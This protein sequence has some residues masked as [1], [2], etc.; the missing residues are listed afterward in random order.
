MYGGARGQIC[1]DGGE[2]EEMANNRG[3]A[4]SDSARHYWIPYNLLEVSS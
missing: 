4:V 3:R 1:S 2:G